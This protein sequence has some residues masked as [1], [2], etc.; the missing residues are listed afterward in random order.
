MMPTSPQPFITEQKSTLDTPFVAPQV[1]VEENAWIDDWIAPIV[2]GALLI[3]CGVLC[4]CC[5]KREWL[6]F[7]FCRGRKVSA[8]YIENGS[9]PLTTLLFQGNASKTRAT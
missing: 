9:G 8:C 7:Q 5:Y 1:L 3:V 6:A 2:V 4:V